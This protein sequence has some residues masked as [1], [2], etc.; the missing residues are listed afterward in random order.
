MT[1]V[2]GSVVRKK[3]NK[4]FQNTMRTATVAGFTTISIPSAPVDG[5]RHMKD[6]DCVYLEGCLGPV[7]LSILEE[8]E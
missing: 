3:S 1:I 7:V 8:V 4:P 6:V 2:V 5:V